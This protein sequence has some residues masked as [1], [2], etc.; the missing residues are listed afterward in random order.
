MSFQTILTRIDNGVGIITLNRPE[1][2]NALNEQL[3]SEVLQA[4]VAMEAD[5]AVAV[6]VL[7]GSDRAFAAGADIKE[8][9]DKSF[10]DVF[11]EQ[12][13]TKTWER[14]ASARKPTIAAVSGHAVGGGFELALMCDIIV[15]AECARFALPEIR[16]GV[17]PGAGGTQRLTRVVGKALAMDMILTGRA[18][19]GEEA[20]AAGAVSRVVADGTH[21]DVALEIAGQIARSSQPILMIAKEAVN[22][23]Y[24]TH[25]AEGIHLERRLLYTTFATE[26][27]REGMS[28]FVEKRKPQFRNR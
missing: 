2:L 24:E 28:A 12:F 10:I 27:R 1:A 7:T 14:V 6:I 15:A 8:I 25:L 3:T 9:K 17:I 23:A 18:I 11:S 19:T 13:I 4:V 16:I 26:D 20:R 22:K 21:L 5:P